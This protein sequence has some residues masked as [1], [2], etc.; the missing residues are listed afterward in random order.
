MKGSLSWVL[1]QW[2]SDTHSIWMQLNGIGAYSQVVDHNVKSARACLNKDMCMVMHPASY[3]PRNIC[4]QMLHTVAIQHVAI[5][6]I[7]LAV[8]TELR[9]G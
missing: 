9:R 6:H 5:V 7:P 1:L 8:D 4:T 2:L 3:E